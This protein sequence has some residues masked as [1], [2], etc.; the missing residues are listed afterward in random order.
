VL[1]D[2][3]LYGQDRIRFHENDGL[4]CNALWV[5][6]SRLPDGVEL[7]PAG[8]PPLIESGTMAPRRD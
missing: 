3:R 5:S 7:Y 1:G 8:L 4:V 6:P 2:A